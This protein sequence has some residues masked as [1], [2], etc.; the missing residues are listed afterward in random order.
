MVA[1]PLMMDQ[2]SISAMSFIAP[3]ITFNAMAIPIIPR[4]F[5][6]FTDARPFMEEDRDFINTNRAPRPLPS[7][8]KSILPRDRTA[9]T[10]TRTATARPMNDHMLALN[11]DPFT[12]LTKATK[13]PMTPSNPSRPWIRTSGFILPSPLM[14]LTIIQTPADKAKMP[15]P[16]P[17]TSVL[18]DWTLERALTKATMPIANMAKIVKD[19]TNAAGSSLAIM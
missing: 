12:P 11:V 16:I 5:V 19:P 3:T 8:T 6:N 1:T 18:N 2:T 13:I 15:I 17:F 9:P 7:A 10:R 4:P 14:A